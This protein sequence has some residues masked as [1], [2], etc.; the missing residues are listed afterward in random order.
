MS[1]FAGAARSLGGSLIINPFNIDQTVKSI[2]DAFEM[3]P[4]ERTARHRQNFDMVSTNTAAKVNIDN[5]KI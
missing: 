5:M 1:E 2:F 4:K 3:S